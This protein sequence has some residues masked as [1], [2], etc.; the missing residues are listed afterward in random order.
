MA[1]NLVLNFSRMNIV[2]SGY[3]RMGHEVEKVALERKHKIVAIIDNKND[4]QDKIDTIKNADVII[5]FSFPETAVDNFR[6]CFE[7]GIPLVSGTT[8][9]YDKMH[10]VKDFCTKNN[11][12]FFYAHNFSIGVNIFF[13]ANKKL[14]KMIA[15][16]GGY[17]PSMEETHHIHK[18]DS[19]SGTAIR[20]AEDIIKEFE[21]IEKWKNDLN[22]NKNELSIISKREGEITGEHMITY[23]S[24]VDE[25][26]ISHSAKNRKG[27]ALGAVVAA[28]FLLGKKGI[29]TMSDLL[30]V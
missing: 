6:R 9:W 17:S 23:Q 12:S 2:I 18:L 7:I 10:E 13:E 25:I 30:K 5:D 8:G 22:I 29:F 4:W 19:P 20:L 11:A 28:E 24:D 26:T 14:A 3:G 15:S 1:L 21:G 16:V 27:F